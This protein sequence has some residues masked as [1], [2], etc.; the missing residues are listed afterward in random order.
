MEEK[1]GFLSRRIRLKLWQ[2]LLLIIG[3]TALSALLVWIYCEKI[4]S[5]VYTNTVRSQLR[6]M[7]TES[8]TASGDPSRPASLTHGSSPRT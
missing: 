6:I 2:K 5:P 1:K 3:C 8:L 4:A 7:D